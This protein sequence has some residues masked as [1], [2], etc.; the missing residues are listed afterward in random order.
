[1]ATTQFRTVEYNCSGSTSYTYSN[2]YDEL[3]NRL[4]EGVDAGCITGGDIH[5]FVD[6]IGWVVCE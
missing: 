1:M 6:G 4:D 2:D 5:E 3:V